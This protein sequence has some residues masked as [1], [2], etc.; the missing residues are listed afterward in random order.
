MYVIDAIDHSVRKVPGGPVETKLDMEALGGGGSK[1][2][3][4]PLY[5]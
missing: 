4:A 3:K 5:A 1:G 2:R